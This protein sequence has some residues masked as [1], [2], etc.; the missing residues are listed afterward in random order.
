[1]K[2][3]FLILIA[4]LLYAQAASA[5]MP[6]ANV[7][8]YCHLGRPDHCD[9]EDE[10]GNTTQYTY[11]EFVKFKCGKETEFLGLEFLKQNPQWVDVYDVAVYGK[12]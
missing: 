1:L 4:A 12:K 2:H 6:G 11:E 10:Q 5:G 8:A 9:V 7:V 3:Y